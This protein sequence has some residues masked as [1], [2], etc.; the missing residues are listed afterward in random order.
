MPVHLVIEFYSDSGVVGGNL[1]LY[2]VLVWTLLS[3]TGFSHGDNSSSGS[4]LVL[5]VCRM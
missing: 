3:N 4:S 2:L 1:A 5:I